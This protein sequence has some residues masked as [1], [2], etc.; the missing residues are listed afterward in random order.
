V[1]DLPNDDPRKI[2]A[3]E[4]WSIVAANDRHLSSV[5]MDWGGGIVSNAKFWN[6]LCPRWVDD[7]QWGGVG[8]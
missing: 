1:W 8:R 4:D 7:P 6:G 3:G 5:V 2:A